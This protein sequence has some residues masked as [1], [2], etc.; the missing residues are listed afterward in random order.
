MAHIPHSAS[1]SSSWREQMIPQRDKG[2]RTNYH[3]C[4]KYY[5]NYTNA[6]LTL[7]FVKTLRELQLYDA[8]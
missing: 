6:N 2:E 7:R 5:V 3:T 1:S 4:E 8:K